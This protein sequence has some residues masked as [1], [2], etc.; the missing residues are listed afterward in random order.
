MGERHADRSPRSSSGRG[1]ICRARSRAGWASSAARQASTGSRA[2]TPRPSWRARS[3]PPSATTQRPT[4]TGCAGYRGLCTAGHG[5]RGYSSPTSAPCA[6][7]RSNSGRPRSSTASSI[8]PVALYPGPYLVG[9]V[10]LGWVLGSLVADIGFYVLRDL[11]LRAVQVPAGSAQARR[12]RRWDMDPQRRSQLRDQLRAGA[13]SFANSSPST[14]PR[15]WFSTPTGWRRS[16]R[17]SRSSCPD[18]GCT[19][20]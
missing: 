3:A 13:G 12:Q 17:C 4:S 10:A 18:S 19:T 20:R 11:Q 7:S 15:C 1:V 16:T 8:R 6:A 9:N 5:R 14:A 2:R